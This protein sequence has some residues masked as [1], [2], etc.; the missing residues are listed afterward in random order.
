MP[1]SFA[2]SQAYRS[3]NLVAIGTRTAWPDNEQGSAEITVSSGMNGTVHKMVVTVSLQPYASCQNTE[4]Q[5]PQTPITHRERMTVTITPRDSDNFLITQTLVQYRSLLYYE[6][7]NYEQVLLLNQT[8]TAGT[9]NDVGHITFPPLRREGSYKLSLQLDDGWD[10]SV[11]D[12]GQCQ[13]EPKHFWVSCSAGSRPGASRKCVRVDHCA[14]AT[15]HMNGLPLGQVDVSDLGDLN[16][17]V[18]A[19]I[20][21]SE[22]LSVTLSG[23]REGKPAG[24]PSSTFSDRIIRWIP[25]NAVRDFK[26]S[27]RLKVERTGEFKL[28]LVSRNSTHSCTL[29]NQLTVGCRAG[30]EEHANQCT[31]GM[32]LWILGMMHARTPRFYSAL[33]CSDIADADSSCHGGRFRHRTR[34]VRGAPAV[35]CPQEPSPHI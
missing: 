9:R 2:K 22:H 25:L 29:L 7:E 20:G 33:W 17:K 27:D 6:Q 28:E 18:S 19:E 11:G 10:N 12:H 8:H 26:I 35:S 21:T 32:R 23:N 14:D 34:S 15:V 1:L 16:S 5:L 13:L 31:P 24:A 4:F 3:Y 30:F